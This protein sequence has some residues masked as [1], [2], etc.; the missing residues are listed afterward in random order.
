MSAFIITRIH[1]GD[2]DAWRPMFDQ[3]LPRAREKAIAQRVFRSADDPNQVFILLEFDSLEDARTAERRLLDSRVLD[4]FSDKHGPNVLVETSA[5]A[6]GEV[7]LLASVGRTRRR[8]SS[9]GRASIGRCPPGMTSTSTS[10]RSRATRR[11]KASGNS[12]S[13]RGARTPVGTSGHASSGHGSLNIP[14]PGA[15]L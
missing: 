8:A 6:S 13:S 5:R 11:W 1:V 7:K 3:D 2:Y 4:R 15:P 9:R 14:A 10:R 12:L